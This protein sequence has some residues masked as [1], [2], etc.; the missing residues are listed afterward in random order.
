LASGKV[1]CWGAVAMAPGEGDEMELVREDED[2]GLA[3][4]IHVVRSARRKVHAVAQR[5]PRLLPEIE[6]AIWLGRVDNELCAVRGGGA[7]CWS[8][9]SALV[10]KP[11]AGLAGAVE[12]A[13]RCALLADGRVACREISPEGADGPPAAEAAEPTPVAGLSDVVQVA[14]GW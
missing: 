8:R 14:G 13:G 6:G 12:L 5:S 9:E 11:V 4:T 10:A 7:L 1:A 3:Y 2:P